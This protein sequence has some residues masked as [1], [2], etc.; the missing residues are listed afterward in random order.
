[1][2][3]LALLLPTPGAPTLPG[4]ALPT[5]AQWA[6]VRACPVVSVA[7]ESFGSGA[8]V[9]VK[10]GW[11]YVLTAAHVVRRDGL[12]VSFVTPE[13]YPKAAWFAQKPE[14]V[15]R[16][17]E[18]DVGL[19]RFRVEDGPVPTVLPMAPVGERPTRFPVPAYTAGAAVGEP[20]TVRADEVR[21]KR[22]VRREGGAVAFFWETDRPPVHGRSGGPLLDAAGRIIG[23]CSATQSGKGYFAHL[24]EVQAALKTGGYGWLVPARP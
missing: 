11:A 18:A 8:V 19:V 24:D 22:L 12:I 2:L 6:A 14:V 16:W 21:A 5:A 3:A 17:P 9:G 20:P 13:S 15:G 4:V 7:G 1:M 23:V 10:D